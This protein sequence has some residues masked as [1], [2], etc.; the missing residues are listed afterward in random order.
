MLIFEYRVTSFLSS[1]ADSYVRIN[2]DLEDNVV[3]CFNGKIHHYSLAKEEIA[4][5]A[6]IIE[7]YPE[8]FN[9]KELEPNNTPGDMR[10]DFTFSTIAKTCSFS[11][12]NIL[13]YGRLPRKNATLALRAAR[14]IK[15][16]V[17]D[18]NGIYTAVPN[19]LQHWPKH[20]I[21]SG[22]IHI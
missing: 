5:V 9:V 21:R 8:L 17:L 3:A 4:K 22:K 10:Y 11:G 7:S 13:D 15:D 6:K 14:D 20:T 2:S 12:F 19:R 16:H 18:L 1:N